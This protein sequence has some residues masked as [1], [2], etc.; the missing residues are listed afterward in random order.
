MSSVQGRSFFSKV[1][2]ELQDLFAHTPGWEASA[3]AT[4]KYVAQMLET[5]IT[6]ADPTAAPKVNEAISRVQAAMA[7]ASVV[8][9]EAGPKPTLIKYLQAI[10]N[11]AAE[12]ESA[13]GVKDP[14]TTLKLNAVLGT[15]THEVN[16]ILSEVSET[17]QP[18]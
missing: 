5:I 13:S 4:L 9:K 10:N 16:A 12:L 1:K 6:L 14:Q 17:P 8:I 15:I 11:N 3:S 18:A 7:A 2:A